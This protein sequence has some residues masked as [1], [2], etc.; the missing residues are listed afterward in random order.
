MDFS[1]GLVS[2]KKISLDDIKNLSG[3]S[4]V[5]FSK[6]DGNIFDSAMKSPEDV[7]ADNELKSFR[8][9]VFLRFFEDNDSSSKTD[10]TDLPSLQI[11]PKFEEINSKD[12]GTG[13]D[14]IMD[15][16]GCA[17]AQKP[18]TEE[19]AEYEAELE[20]ALA[21]YDE[22]HPQEKTKSDPLV[23]AL[24]KVDTGKSD[25]IKSFTETYKAMHP[26][27]EKQYDAYEY[28]RKQASIMM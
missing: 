5:D 7:F 6:F 11:N 3:K 12:S 13:V 26:E 17:K 16:G 8:D 23:I 9:E 24:E 20:K 15:R 28:A 27:F 25:F 21:E 2:H 4:D 14:I 1:F 19:W 22:K 10:S 18:E